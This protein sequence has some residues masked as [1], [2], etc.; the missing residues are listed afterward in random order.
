MPWSAECRTI[1][2]AGRR[3]VRAMVIAMP[4][5]MTPFRK[6]SNPSNE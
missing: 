2:A 1:T 6:A 3:H 4:E 5:R